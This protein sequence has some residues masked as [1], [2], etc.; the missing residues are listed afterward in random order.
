MNARSTDHVPAEGGSFEQIAAELSPSL[1]RYLRRYTGESELAED[2]LQETLVR[3]AR[4]LPGFANRSSVKTWAHSIASRVAADHFRKP[5]NR[6]PTIGM[7]ESAQPADTAPAAEE[8]VVAVEMN[9]CVRQ[10]IDALPEAYRAALVLHDL[11][12][13]SARQVAEI[14]DC[15][16]ATAKIRIHRGRGQLKAALRE[17][18]RFYRD[19]DDV[20]RC[21]RKAT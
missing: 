13:R 10:A 3:M 11:E 5:G 21:E 9:A 19:G 14:G 2:L 12:E 18:C 6:L 20:L 15:S 16:V 17:Q 7:D 1:L 8:R 4:G